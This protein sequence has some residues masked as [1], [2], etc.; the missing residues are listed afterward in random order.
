MRIIGGQDDFILDE[1][2]VS[3]VVPLNKKNRPSGYWWAFASVMLLSFIMLQLPAAWVIARVMPNNPYLDNVSGNLWHGQGDWHYK[4]AQG[5][6]SW[7]T[8][9]WMLLFFRVSANVTLKTGDTQLQAIITRSPNHWH[10][11][12]LNGNIQPETLQALIPWQ[13]PSSPII[14]KNLS[15]D[16]YT[17]GAFSS[18]DGQ[19][20]WGGGLLGY[21]YEGRVERATL[22]PLLG[23]LSLDRDRLH[24][25][26]TNGQKE[27]MGDFYLSGQNATQ[28][29]MMLDVQLTQ[30]LLLNVAGYHGQAGLDTAVI[31]VRQP[32][33][34][35]GAM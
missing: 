35:L 23:G 6:I 19:L 32:L 33:S 24:F 4:D 29:D 13:W 5:V 1:W 22:P 27:R 9:P 17:S 31:A 18:V 21:P 14:V 20:S 25:A 30:R 11:D 28:K 3:R 12:S 15:I 7:Q 16:Q 2:F 26:L 8:R 10:L 34:S